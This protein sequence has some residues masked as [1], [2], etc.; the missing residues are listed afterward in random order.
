MFV[1]AGWLAMKVGQRGEGRGKT[2]E[3]FL[4]LLTGFVSHLI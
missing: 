2:Y 4:S 3:G 1:S